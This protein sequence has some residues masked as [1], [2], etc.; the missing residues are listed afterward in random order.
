[1]GTPDLQETAYSRRE[2]NLSRFGLVKQFKKEFA[3]KHSYSSRKIKLLG[4]TKRTPKT[5]VQRST[6]TS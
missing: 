4:K 1:M 2:S 5:E 6:E 3:R